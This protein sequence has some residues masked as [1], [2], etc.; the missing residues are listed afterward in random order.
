MESKEQSVLLAIC[1][2]GSNP[3]L[4]N[5]IEQLDKCED[6]PNVSLRVVIVLNQPERIDEIQDRLSQYDVEIF[7]E[8][9]RGFAYV[10]NRALTLRKE[11]ESLLFIDDDELLSIGEEIPSLKFLEAHL[12]ANSLFRNSI[13][14]GP[15]LPIEEASK[16]LVPNWRQTHHKDLGEIMSYASGGNL[17]I[18]AGIFNV[19]HIYFDPFFNGGGS[20]SDLAIRLHKQG[21]VTRWVPAS[22]LYEVNAPNRLVD[23]WQHF[24]ELMN[25]RIEM[26]VGMRNQGLFWNIHFLLFNIKKLFGAL[27]TINED[28][29]RYTHR[30]RFYLKNIQILVLGPRGDFEIKR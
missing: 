5:L 19:V 21:I 22:V 7:T 6:L 28:R 24:R 15:Y 23:D 1:T 12:H 11:D 13:F 14:V 27:L 29:S 20:D 18:P 4:F 30:I 26:L 8:M 25:F 3:N 17:F 16:S 9:N 10:R 2:L